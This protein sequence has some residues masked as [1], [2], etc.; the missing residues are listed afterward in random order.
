MASTLLNGNCCV[1]IEFIHKFVAKLHLKSCVAAVCCNY[2]I[3]I[4]VI[5]IITLTTA[6]KFLARGAN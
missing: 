1:P 3:V 5:I 4:V 2:Y 6:S